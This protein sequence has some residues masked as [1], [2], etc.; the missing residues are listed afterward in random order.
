MKPVRVWNGG[1]MG[2]LAQDD[3][4]TLLVGQ[5]PGQGHIP[6]VCRA[7]ISRMGPGIGRA[8]QG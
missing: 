8:A 2:F 3:W 7:S 5:R 1:V 4:Q 6:L